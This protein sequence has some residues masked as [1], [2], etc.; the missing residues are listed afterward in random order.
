LSE[1]KTILF[2]LSDNVATITLNRPNRMNALI[3]L[4]GQEISAAIDVALASG[5]RALIFT[6][7][8]KGFCAGADL[9]PDGQDYEGLPDDLGD[10]L[11][12]HYN[13]VL[14]KLAALDIPIVSAINGAA[15]GAG[16]GFALAA[17]IVIAARSSYLLLAF[18]NVGV[19]PDAGS[20]WFVAKGAGRAKALEMALLGERLKA[21]DALA[22]GL[23][24]RVVDDEKLQEEARAIARKLA[25]G[26]TAAISMIRKQVA[27]AL[28]QDL[29]ETLEIERANQS[30]AS[31]TRDF[32]EAIT[33]FAEKRA[34]KFEGR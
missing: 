31:R 16:V 5:A 7:A 29:G 34:P 22:A 9:V 23:V 21:E 30:A 27:A 25:S 14:R 19:V 8:G 2:D 20:T 28:N 26:P 3:P 15:A 1:Y 6:G 4:L 32:H 10:L 11:H 24:T 13:P 33:A 18:V 12:D 17:D